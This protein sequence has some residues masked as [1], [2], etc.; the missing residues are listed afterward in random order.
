MKLRKCIAILLCITVIIG[1]CACSKG[2]T[3]KNEQQLKWWQNTI[4][5]EAYPSSFKDTDGN[6]YGDIP[7]ITSELDYLASLGVGAIWITPIFASPMKDNGY[8]VADYYSINPLYGTMEDVETLI[9][10]AD[11]RNIKIVMDLVFNHTSDESE[12]FKESSS[13]RNNDKNDWYIW[14]DAREDGS[15]PNNWRGIFG[16]SAWTWCEARQQYYLHTFAD[17]QPDLN[18]ENPDVRNS[19]FDIANFW[20]DKGVG[21]FRVDAVTYIK[22]PDLMLDGVADGTDGLSGIHNM[23]ANTEGILDFL[24]EF[25]EKVQ[26]GTDIFVVGEANGVPNEQ[27]EDWC[28]ENGVFDMIFSFDLVNIQFVNG[29]YWYKTRD[30]K[31]SEFKK[32]I[33]VFQQGT[34]DVWVPLFFENHDQP[35]SI[36]HFLPDCT[37][38]I[39]GAKALATLLMT[40]RGTPFIY[41]GEEIGMTN[42][43]R[44]TIEEY[45]DISS[46][47]QYKMALENGLDREEA[48]QCVRDY[49]RDNARSPMQWDMTANSGFTRGRAWLAVADNYL[50]VNVG[51]EDN[52]PNSVLNWYR[53]LSEL[54]KEHPALIDGS[55]NELRE[56]SEELFMYIRENKKEK[57]LVVINFTGKQ[58]DFIPDNPGSTELLI[59]SYGDDSGDILRPYEARCYRQQY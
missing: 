29:E 38:K 53:Q 45:N 57:I 36:N 22:K 16:G 21:G 44:D 39:N 58:V 17:F 37:D 35:R 18:W 55:F 1:F 54:R 23:T 56:D 28:G 10:E 4:V 6:G 2:Q 26:D 42:V 31:L 15:A 48:L 27:L 11:K 13:D 33:H 12:W 14:A 49:S 41:Q 59:S 7:G 40:L 30:F 43:N 3:G 25:K 32:I 24:H 5:Y 9:E 34:D 52:D 51:S 19:L 47:N 8:D 20:I 46:H 50:A